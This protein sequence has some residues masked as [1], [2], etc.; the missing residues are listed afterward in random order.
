MLDTGITLK[1]YYEKNLGVVSE[2]GDFYTFSLTLIF[3]SA[4][5]ISKGGNYLMERICVGASRNLRRYP[6][7]TNKRTFLGK[8]H[9]IVSGCL[10]K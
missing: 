2:L 5:D 7:L 8:V 9:R 6:A 10:P 3:I 1:F 4:W